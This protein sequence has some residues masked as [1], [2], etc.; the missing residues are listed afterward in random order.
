MAGRPT[1][2]ELREMLRALPRPEPPS[3]FAAGV[4]D[5]GAGGRAAPPLPPL[6]ARRGSGGAGRFGAVGPVR[7]DGTGTEEPRVAEAPAPAEPAVA[8]APA[9]PDVQEFEEIVRQYRL[10]AEELEAMRRLGGDSAEGPILRIGGD[11][12]VDLFLDLESYLALPPGRRAPRSWSP[13]P[14]ARAGDPKFPGEEDDDREPEIL[15]RRRA[16]ACRRP[17][18][19]GARRATPQEPAGPSRSWRSPPPKGVPR[20]PDPDPR[21]AAAARGGG[22]FGERLSRNP[23]DGPHRRTAPVL[24]RPEGRRTLV[25]RVAEDSPAATAGFEV[26]DVI[27]RIAGDP[28][29]NSWDVV[30]SVTHFDPEEEV[31]IEVVRDGAP[32]TL[33]ATLGER[34]GGVWV[35]SGDGPNLEEFHFEMPDLEGLEVLRELRGAVSDETREAVREAIE[36]AREKMSEFDHESLAERLAEAE[37]RLRELEQK[38]A[39]RER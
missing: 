21:P 27:T 4:M 8:E 15:P 12:D 37:A 33:T 36:K 28:T 34:K 23:V 30:R 17:R 10:L 13:P 1:D 11:E 29:E 6:A 3:G 2:D 7:W 14:P 20:S 9:D 25:S 24:R 18:G 5:P 38:L 31:A 39:E 35:S 32:V 22:P 19:P 16:R 26:G